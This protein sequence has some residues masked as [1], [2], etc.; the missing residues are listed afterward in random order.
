MFKN[1]TRLSLLDFFELT[2]AVAAALYVYQS[3]WWKFEKPWVIGALSIAA[4][5]LWIATRIGKTAPTPGLFL[6][7]Y[8]GALYGISDLTLWIEL[9]SFDRVRKIAW[10]FIVN[11][12]P[13]DAW[14]DRPIN[15]AYVTCMMLIPA[16]GA[17]ALWL[18][19]VRT[20]Q[21]FR[22][23]AD[24]P[25]QRA[26]QAQFGL[27]LTIA[28]LPLLFAAWMAMPKPI[29]YVR[30]V[31]LPNG[32]DTRETRA[33]NLIS[34]WTVTNDRA[35]LLILLADKRVLE[36]DANKG[37]VRAMGTLECGALTGQGIEPGYDP[38]G[39]HFVSSAVDAYEKIWSLDENRLLLCADRL[40][41]SHPLYQV[42]DLRTGKQEPRAVELKLAARIRCVSPSGV[43]AVVEEFGADPT[44]LEF[45]VWNLQTMERQ[46]SPQIEPLHNTDA[47]F[48]VNNSGSIV[49]IVKYLE[50][51]L[52]PRPP[53][54]SQERP[55]L[56]RQELSDDGRLLLDEHGSIFGGPAL[57]CY[58]SGEINLPGC[59]APFSGMPP[60]RALLDSHRNKVITLQNDIRFRD[61]DPATGLPIIDHL[62]EKAYR[63]RL[64]RFDSS[65]SSFESYSIGPVRFHSPSGSSA[66][67]T[68]Q[69]DR[70]WI[71]D[72]DEI[73]YIFH[74]FKVR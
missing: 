67:F 17:G 38:Y 3:G 59:E 44:R 42:F 56:L 73:G 10:H 47:H 52:I 35:R 64:F 72:E 12:G 68:A 48:A 16:I 20:T 11:R 70:L 37:E 1:L 63:S 58:P 13:F 36:L 60:R 4:I 5:L 69:G 25:K 74:E 22:G 55:I 40:A 71:M 65:D 23:K 46:S 21:I 29:Q 27:L 53:S 51:P 61:E 49:R 43:Y 45:A 31:T 7:A 66:K 18:A 32:F 2:A 57:F 50:P 34:S 30:S 9:L 8:T 33:L 19:I 24:F 39:P 62:I 41:N 26:A 54:I 15:A 6:A 28:S 14:Y